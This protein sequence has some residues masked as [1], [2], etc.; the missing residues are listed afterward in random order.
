MRDT[1]SVHRFLPAI[2]AAILSFWHCQSFA[3][4][5]GPLPIDDIPIGFPAP[6]N[7]DP[8]DLS[9]PD[10]PQR[11]E[12]PISPIR[13]ESDGDTAVDD[14]RHD[15]TFVHDHPAQAYHTPSAHLPTAPAVASFAYRLPPIY[16]TTQRIRL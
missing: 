3:V 13:N 11:A 4:A 5:A 8:S 6:Q 7:S 10:R 1:R 2:V 15:I 12:I 9:L 16:R 14:A